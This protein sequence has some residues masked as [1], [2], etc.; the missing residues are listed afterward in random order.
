MNRPSAACGARVASLVISSWLVTACTGIEPELRTLMQATAAVEGEQ[1]WHGGPPVEVADTGPAPHVRVLHEAF[2]PARAM[3]LVSFI[4]RFYRAPAN[5]GYDEVLNK[6]TKTL[7]EAG[8]DGEDPRLSLELLDVAEVDAW[9]PVSGELVL[10]VDGQ[11]PRVLHSFKESADVDRVM[12]PVHAPSCDL[13]AEVALAL[14]DVKKGMVLVTEVPAA[15]VIPRAKSRGAAAVISAS[16]ETFNQDPVSGGERH[17]DA[18]Q[19]RTHSPGLDM[20]TAQIS[21]RNLQMIGEEVERATRRGA[22]VRLRFRAETKVERR[23]LRTLMA[24]IEGEKHPEQA[25]AMVSHVQ[26]P[27]ACDNATGVA[28]LVEGA[29]SMVELLKAKKLAWPGRSLVFL[30]GDEFRQSESWLATTDLEPIVGISSDMTGQSKDTHAI[31]LLERNPDPGAITVLSPDF[32]TP[33]GAGQVSEDEVRKMMNGLPVIARCAMTDVSLLEGGK[34]KSDEHPWEGGS[35]HDIFIAR[36]IPAVLFWHFTDF[37]Y[38][39]SLDRMGFVNPEEMRRTGVA[40]LAT[41]L[42]VSCAEPTDL[43]RYI[44]SLE[45]EK[46]LRMDAATE[47]NDKELAELWE[48]WSNGAREWLRNL[49]LGID[50]KIPR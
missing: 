9:T 39:T 15:Q 16:L 6:L 32:H 47:F 17:L 1:Q 4:D 11:E 31:A 49:C 12:L 24:M 2:R 36:G 33:W 26:E 5:E 21:P 45:K 19:F 38:H 29:V 28:G 25:I 7:R 44:D 18:I 3:E 37:T 13:M 23:P 10:L 27:G 20:P 43:D 22:K 34:W 8:F 46:L 41:A 42:A 30:W 14:E 48:E 50:E 35:D 40:L